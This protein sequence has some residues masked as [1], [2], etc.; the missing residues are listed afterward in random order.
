MFPARAGDKKALDRSDCAQ[1]A[2]DAFTLSVPH[3]LTRTAGPVM[4]DIFSLISANY[5]AVGGVVPSK[6]PYVAVDPKAYT[7]TWEGVYADKTKFSFQISQVSG[8]RAQVKYTDA[9][10][11]KFQQVLIKD[12]SFKIGNSKF[13]LQ[14]AGHAQVKTV[15]VNAATGAST[16]NT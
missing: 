16:L 5:K 15:V 1:E 9:Q 4:S 2:A 12:N 8:F 14:K 13:T 11:T 3:S 6:T 10:G 7:G